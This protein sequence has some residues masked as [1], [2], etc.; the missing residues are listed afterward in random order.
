MTNYLI[1]YLRKGSEVGTNNS[2]KPTLSLFPGLKKNN[3]ARKAVK[4]GARI[5]AMS[6]L[7]W[8]SNDIC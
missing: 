5:K 1:F 8:R 3:K 4:H 2:V 7:R 6:V